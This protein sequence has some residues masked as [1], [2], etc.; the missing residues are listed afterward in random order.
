MI[1]EMNLQDLENIKGAIT[2]DNIDA[3]AE[4]E[5]DPAPRCIYVGQVC[6][7]IDSEGH[8]GTH[9]GLSSFQ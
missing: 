3:L 5:S 8:V 4:K 6:F 7:G 2:F 9:F 1:S